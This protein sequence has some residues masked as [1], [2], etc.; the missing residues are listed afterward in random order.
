MRR[1][2]LIVLLI[3]TAAASPPDDDGRGTFISPMGE[4]FRGPGGPVAQVIAWF[5]AADADHDGRLTEAE[6]TAD[7]ARFFKTLD[8]DGDGEI[9]PAEL[10]HYETVVAPEVHVAGDV[11]VRG[12]GGARGGSGGRHGGRGGGG[13]GGG[14]GGRSGSAGSEDA[15]PPSSRSSSAPR[16]AEGAGRFGLLDLPEP[17]AAADTDLDR[18]ITRRE[19]AAAASARFDAL[20]TDSDGF[21][22]LAKL[23]RR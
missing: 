1:A 6:F 14:R 5:N 23:I 20:D 8:T 15:S 10:R 13:G 19:F 12:G 16:G 18:S 17:V 7:A 2:G 11:G 22:T 3:A 4:P 9:D 21:L